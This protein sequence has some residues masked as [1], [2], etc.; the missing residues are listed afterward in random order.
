[1]A[2]TRLVSERIKI[3]TQ[4]TIFGGSWTQQKLELLSKYLSA[5]TKIFRKNPNA[6][7]YTTTYVDAFAGT[8]VIV[9]PA[10]GGLAK[11]FPGIQQADEKFRKGSVRRALEVEPPF[12]KYVFIEK[13]TKK[14]QELRALA[15]QFPGKKIDVINEDANS[16]LLKWCS[17]L[18]TERER[19]V[20][21]LDPF[22]AAVEWKV[23]SALA[24]T[25]AVDLWI[26]FPY[27]AVNRMLMRNRKPQGALAERLTKVFGT[28]DWEKSFYSSRKFRSLLTETHLEEDHKSVDHREIIDFFMARLRREFEAVADA[29]PLHHSRGSLL[30]MLIFAAGNASSAKTGI[31][32]AN[33]IKFDY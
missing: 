18:N 32:I 1:V 29:K 11:L 5:Y 26:L 27:S 17:S 4:Q 13:N 19:A 16:A 25:R 28:C 12:D 6:Q 14:C 20:V 2:L 15:A 3:L 33:S 8:G 31:K 23:I 7:F 30:F 22:G 9:R 24:K 10:L 21:F